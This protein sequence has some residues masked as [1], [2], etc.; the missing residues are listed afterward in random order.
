LILCPTVEN[1][2]FVIS[3]S[4]KYPFSITGVW[5]IVS[6]SYADTEAKDVTEELLW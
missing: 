6:P 2:V 1:L 5:H 4:S 3:P